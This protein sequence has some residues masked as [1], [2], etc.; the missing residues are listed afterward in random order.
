MPRRNRN[1]GEHAYAK[2]GAGAGTQA[3]LAYFPPPLGRP[4]RTRRY[5]NPTAAA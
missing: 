1:A 3:G 2:L 5:N 4:N